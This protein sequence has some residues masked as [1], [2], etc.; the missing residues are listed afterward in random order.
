M[1]TP[2][3]RRGT[4]STPP[5]E[6]STSR[7]SKSTVRGAGASGLGEREDARPHPRRPRSTGPRRPNPRR[8]RPSRISPAAAPRAPPAPRR[9]VVASVAGGGSGR[10][11]WR[12]RR[13]GERWRDGSGGRGGAGS[14][15][16][17][18]MRGLDERTREGIGLG[19][20]TA[21]VAYIPPAGKKRMAKISSSSIERPALPKL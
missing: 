14:G 6:H 16:A 3:S 12:K 15:A 17:G 9:R 5:V 7:S 4:A 18:R 19:F 11:W 10:Q 21:G 20:S 8:P 1:V 2:Y 13:R